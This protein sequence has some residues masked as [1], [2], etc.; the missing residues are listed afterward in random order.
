MPAFFT[1]AP[2]ET[3]LPAR[4]PSSVRSV[5]TAGRQ[6]KRCN[7]TLH[8]SACS[9]LCN[10]L[11]CIIAPSILRGSDPMIFQS[12]SKYREFNMFLTVF[13][14][15]FWIIPR[16]ELKVISDSSCTVE[17]S[18]VQCVNE[19][20][21]LELYSI[22]F[23]GIDFDFMA[24]DVEYNPNNVPLCFRRPAW[25]GSPRGRNTRYQFR[26]RLEYCVSSVASRC[27]LAFL[28]PNR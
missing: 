17:L 5:Y 18:N 16:L 22:Q 26:Y 20:N 12:L 8:Q 10:L 9:A 14:S 11:S 3:F 25:S 6:V 27:A 19:F 21:L 1:R 24:Y 4:N 2:G 15:T 28:A 13:N 23:V 7:H